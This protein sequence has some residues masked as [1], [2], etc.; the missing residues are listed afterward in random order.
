MSIING[1]KGVMDL[2]L[3]LVPKEYIK[4][5]IDQHYKDIIEYK[6]Y[7]NTLKPQHRYE[8]TIERINNDIE[9]ANNITNE[10]RKKEQNRRYELSL[11]R[12]ITY[13]NY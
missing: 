3:S 2:D 13:E 1:Y 12:Q 7:Q 5:T 8:N 4:V 11:R 9:K 10:R 6:K